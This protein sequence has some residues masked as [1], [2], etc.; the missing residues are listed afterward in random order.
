MGGKYFHNAGL[1][2]PIDTQHNAIRTKMT[3]RQR[4]FSIELRRAAGVAFKIV[5][6][7]TNDSEN[8]REKPTEHFV[9]VPVLT[10]KSD[11][12]SQHGLVHRTLL[13]NVKVTVFAIAF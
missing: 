11:A 13:R 5:S 3:S 1:H 10:N 6:F 8:L 4:E 12:A 2:W 7:L 9:S